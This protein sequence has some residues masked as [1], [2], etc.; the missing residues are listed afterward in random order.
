MIRPKVSIV[1]LSFNGSKLG[2]KLF[3]CLDSLVATE[4]PNFEIVFVD[5][6]SADGSV[7]EVRDQYGNF[8]NLKIVELKTNLGCSGGYNA[9]FDRCSSESELV[10]FANNDIVVMPDWLEP[11]VEAMVQDTE[12]GACGPIYLSRDFQGIG[13]GGV[14]LTTTGMFKGIRNTDSRARYFVGCVSAC[15]MTR[16]SLFRRLGGFTTNFFLNYEETD[17]C[18]RLRSFGYTVAV[19][20]RSRIFHYGGSTFESNQ[21]SSLSVWYTARNRFYY[22]YQNRTAFGIATT[23]LECFALILT[24]LSVLYF[25]RTRNAE[26]AIGVIMGTISGFLGMKKGLA[27]YGRRHFHDSLRMPMVVDFLVLFHRSSTL[28]VTESIIAKKLRLNWHNT[29]EKGNL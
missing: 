2:D 6:G 13:Q 9:G 21:M 3:E 15:L 11:L 28:R 24:G 23:A 4:Y 10:V 7:E 27:K 20:S 29:A 16:V 5:N 25:L 26:A 18:E 17:Y 8:G 22:V 14:L 1:V 12:I 19:I